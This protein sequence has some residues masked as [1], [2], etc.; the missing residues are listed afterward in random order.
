MINV[1][2]LKDRL[3]TK[4]VLE[5]Y[6]LSFN[7]NNFAICP[8]H[9]E[10]TPSL[11]VK[12]DQWK[13]FGC[14]EGGDIVNFVEKLFGISFKEALSKLDSD[15]SLGLDKNLN[16]EERRTQIEE[17]RF[18]KQAREYEE[19]LAAEEREIYDFYCEKFRTLSRSILSLEEDDPVRVRLQGFLDELEEDLDHPSRLRMRFEKSGHKFRSHKSR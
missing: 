2:E 14:N 15:F 12:G 10:K 17:M 8:F 6:G 13:C 1:K 16:K 4:E 7:S 11:S 19:R 9:T 3:D 18:L 5:F